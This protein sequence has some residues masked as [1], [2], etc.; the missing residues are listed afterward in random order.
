MTKSLSTKFLFLNK[1]MVDNFKILKSICLTN[2]ILSIA[3][4]F[5]S[6][7]KSFIFLQSESTMKK[8]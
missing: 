8:R 2:C 6:E 5:N 3:L 4:Q 7:N 1:L